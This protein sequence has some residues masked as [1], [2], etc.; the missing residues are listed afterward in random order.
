MCNECLDRIKLSRDVPDLLKVWNAETGNRNSK[1]KS[2]KMNSWDRG[3]VNQ[4]NW[5]SSKECEVFV[6]LYQDIITTWHP[7]TFPGNRRLHE[8][9]NSM[10]RVFNESFWSR[11]IFDGN[12]IKASKLRSLVTNVFQI[13]DDVMR[14]E[15]IVDKF[16]DK[17]RS[18]YMSLVII[19]CRYRK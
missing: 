8:A 7:W 9:L 15:T 3:K 11:N 12:F 19:L 1:L 16:Y 6:V 4:M 10:L 5:K 18:V 14:I 13:F 17:R 2:A